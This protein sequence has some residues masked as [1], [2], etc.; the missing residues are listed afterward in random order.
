[1]CLCFTCHR[2]FEEHPLEWR[3]FVDSKFGGGHYDKMSL[4][5]ND[6]FRGDIQLLID[7]MRAAL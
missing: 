7:A 1:M 3:E 2:Y 5:A 6:V 4:M